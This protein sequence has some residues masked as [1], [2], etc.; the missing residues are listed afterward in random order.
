[1]KGE[2]SE[3]DDLATGTQ[4]KTAGTQTNNGSSNED[5]LDDFHGRDSRTDSDVV[6]IVTSFLT[7]G[8]LNNKAFLQNANHS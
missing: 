4:I 3:T 7:S 6:F 8:R 5:E 1:M 2:G